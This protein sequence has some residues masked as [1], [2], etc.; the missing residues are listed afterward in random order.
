MAK[1]KK[2]AGKRAVG[3]PDIYSNGT[4]YGIQ[5]S[6]ID[7]MKLTINIIIL[8]TDPRQMGANNL[9]EGRRKM[10]ALPG[11]LGNRANSLHS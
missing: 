2:G 10:A 1:A 3:K 5:Y 8:W 11:I 7:N 4:M 9:L 6:S